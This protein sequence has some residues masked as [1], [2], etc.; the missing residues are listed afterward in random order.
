MTTINAGKL[1]LVFGLF[2]GGCHLGWALIVALG[3][4]QP[5][6]DFILRVHFIAPVWTVTPFNLGDAALLVAV[7]GAIGAATGW[8]FA[9]L[10]NWAV[11]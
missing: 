4:G 3:W 8:L 5:A 10:W 7:T 2:L 1:A 11:R 6:L 9:V